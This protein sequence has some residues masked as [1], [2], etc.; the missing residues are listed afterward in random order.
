M[1]GVMKAKKMG[2]GMMQRTG[3][4]VGGSVTVKLNWV[5]TDLQKYTRRDY[6]PTE[7]ISVWEAAS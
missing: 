6:V 2:G 1:G 7:F 3:Y 4:N 5:E